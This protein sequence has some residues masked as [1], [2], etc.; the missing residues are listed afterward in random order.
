MAI[1]VLAGVAVSYS[2][3]GCMRL[4]EIWLAV[5]AKIFS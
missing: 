4:A 5:L 3:G 1:V 2:L